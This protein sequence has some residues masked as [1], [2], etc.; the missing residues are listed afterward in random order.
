MK[1]LSNN[2]IFRWM[3]D[4]TMQGIL[5]EEVGSCD[6]LEDADDF[7]WNAMVDEPDGKKVVNFT[8]SLNPIPFAVGRLT[9]SGKPRISWSVN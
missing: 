2:T 3:Q 7:R 9:K 4:R 6:Q 1:K 8:T 5:H